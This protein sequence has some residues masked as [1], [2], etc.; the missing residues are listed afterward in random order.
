MKRPVKRGEIYYADLSPVIGS[1]QGETRPVLITQNDV[2]NKYSPTTVIVPITGNLKKCRLPTHVVIPES[3]SLDADSLGLVEQIRTID[4]TRLGAYI[5]RIG[6]KVQAEIDNALAV[7]VGI[8]KNLSKKAEV[9][10]LCLCPRCESDFWESGC[11]LIKRGWQR[12]KK[13][14]DFCE[15]RHGLVFGIFNKKLLPAPP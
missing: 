14:C 2:G 6:G 15:T 3:S 8:D 12:D 5:G 7:C 1:E 10:T 9:L 13:I 11:I 4:R